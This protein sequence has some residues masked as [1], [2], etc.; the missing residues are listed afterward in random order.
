MTIPLRPAQADDLDALTAVFLTARGQM[1][2]LP[3]ESEARVKPWVRDSVLGGCEVVVAEVDD[4]PVAFIAL[5]G[6]EIE[7]LYV[8]PFCQ[9]HG[10]GSA[11]LAQAKRM[12]P[13]GLSLYVFEPNLGAIRF[14]ERHGFVTSERSDGQRNE[15]KVADRRMAWEASAQP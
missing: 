9:C 3:R 5:A 2:Y 1:T 7:H 15:E 8:E 13:E 14:Y 11:L 6:A 12:R 4:R 10:I